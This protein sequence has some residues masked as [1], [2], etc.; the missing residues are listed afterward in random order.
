MEARLEGRGAGASRQAAAMTVQVQVEEPAGAHNLYEYD[1]RRQA[2]RLSGVAVRDGASPWE[3]GHVL[4]TR[5]ASGQPLPALVLV[6]VPTLPGCLVPTRLLGAAEFVQEGERL[7]LVLGVPQVDAAF[8]GLRD[9]EGLPGDLRAVARAWAPGFQRWLGAQEAASLVREASEAYWRA[10]AQAESG[11]RAGAAWKVSAPPAGAGGRGEGEPHTWAE[12]LIP[13]LPLRFQRHV[14]EMLLPEERILL[15]IE[16]PEFAPPGRLALLRGR[17]LRQGLLVVTDRQLLTLLDSRPPDG[18]LVDWGYVAKATAVERIESA[19]VE[20]QGS[21]VELKV[22][23]S[24]GGAPSAIPC[25]SRRSMRGRWKRSCGCWEPSP[26]P[27][28]APWPAGMIARPIMAA[29]WI[30]RG[31]WPDTRTWEN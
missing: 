27:A 3:R 12:Y 20:P 26:G 23:A 15:F 22:V 24:A 2:L 18:T 10:K 8:R 29:R 16:R 14:E 31:C 7:Y 13:S 28:D 1:Q 9:V 25:S 17:K 11:V 4:N 6:R 19:W 21:G 30:G 5:S